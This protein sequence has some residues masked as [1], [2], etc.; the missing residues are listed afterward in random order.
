MSRRK[1]HAAGPYRRASGARAADPHAQPHTGASG[2]APGSAFAV[3]FAGGAGDW[4]PPQTGGTGGWE[5]A[6]SAALRIERARMH[7]ARPAAGDAAGG[8]NS[9]ERGAQN[10]LYGAHGSASAP[11]DAARAN[12][13]ALRAG[14]VRPALFYTQQQRQAK[15][16]GVF[17]SDA[18][19][20]HRVK[21][22]EEFPRG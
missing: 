12:A 14:A 18:T 22:K 10:T 19:V 7:T 20:R 15:K 1:H 17:D 13:E 21:S 9:E 4:E 5:H 6:R 8:T 11:I 2:T 16:D 3:N